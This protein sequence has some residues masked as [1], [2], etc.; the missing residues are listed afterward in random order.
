MDK[1]NLT[2]VFKTQDEEKKL[3][4]NVKLAKII[5]ELYQKSCKD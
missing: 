3:L 5:M 4:I 1:L 2:N